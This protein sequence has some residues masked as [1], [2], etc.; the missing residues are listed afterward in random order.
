[1]LPAGTALPHP[2]PP[3]PSKPYSSHEEWATL[4]ILLTFD[5][6]YSSM[7]LRLEQVKS[8]RS[9]GGGDKKPWDIKGPRNI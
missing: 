5:V 3:S 6:L 8:S 7:E 9:S 2:S 1:M 4:L